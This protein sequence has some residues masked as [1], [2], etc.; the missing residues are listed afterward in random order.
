MTWYLSTASG[1]TFPGLRHT[2]AEGVVGLRVYDLRHTFASRFLEAG[3]R[4]TD[5][6]RLLGHSSLKMTARYTHSSEQSRRQAV[7]AL[8]EDCTKE[9]ERVRSFG[10]K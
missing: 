7:E 1:S 4:E 2:W 6:N 9:P 10:Q 8:Y 3:V 5:I